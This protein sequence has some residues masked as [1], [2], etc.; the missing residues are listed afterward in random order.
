MGRR[1]GADRARGLQEVSGGA[2]AARLHGCAVTDGHPP[3]LHLA[4]RIPLAGKYIRVCVSLLFPL[5]LSRHKLSRHEVLNACLLLVTAEDVPVAMALPPCHS[6]QQK[7]RKDHPLDRPT[8]WNGVRSAKKMPFN[9]VRGAIQF[10]SLATR[11]AATLGSTERM[12]VSAAPAD[13]LPWANTTRSVPITR[14][15]AM[16]SDPEILSKVKNEWEGCI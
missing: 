15:A 12:V 7:K 14:P 9:K 8:E 2:G 16:A 5:F 6:P 10:W 3:L 13:T 11:S 1:G 4:P